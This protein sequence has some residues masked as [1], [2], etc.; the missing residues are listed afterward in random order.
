MVSPS[1]PTNAEEVAWPD[2][3]KLFMLPLLEGS[4]D[5]GAYEHSA[6]DLLVSE[7]GLRGTLELIEKN[8]ERLRPWMDVLQLFM[9]NPVESV[10][11]NR[12]FSDAG[13]EEVITRDGVLWDVSEPGDELIRLVAAKA[14][15]E[16][17]IALFGDQ[18]DGSTVDQ[19][20]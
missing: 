2:L 18:W 1:L 11:K 8:I 17:A 16:D 3:D 4:S 13:D 6:V 14:Q 15:L 9:S 10:P 19:S 7:R 5:V 20:G 12:F